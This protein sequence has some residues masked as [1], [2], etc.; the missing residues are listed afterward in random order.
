VAETAERPPHSPSMVR[1][2]CVGKQKERQAAQP[3]LLLPPDQGVR[4]RQE[5]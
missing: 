1:D 2:V 4:A 3:P 5:A